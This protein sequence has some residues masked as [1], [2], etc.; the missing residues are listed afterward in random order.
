MTLIG[1]IVSLVLS[2]LLGYFFTPLVRGIAV[3][4]K[5]CEK[6]N[7]C[8]PRDIAHIGGVAI[9]GAIL[10]TLIP[11]FLFH[12][13]HDPLHRAFLPIFIASGF[14]TF[15]LGIIDDLRS[16]HYLYKLF[17]QIVVA[18]SVSA[19][20]M[21]LLQHFGIVQFS[22]PVALVTF[23]LAASWILVIT[24]SF[25]LIDGIDGL[26]SGLALIAAT[27]F[28]VTGLLF[29]MPIVIAL[30]CVVFGSV[31]AFLRYNFPP[32]KIFMG[33]SGSLFLGLMF[34]LI[35]LLLVIPGRQ[36]FYRVAGSIIVLA[37]PFLDTSLAFSR[38]L[39]TGR[40]IFDADL[41]HIHHILLY[42]M[43]SVRWVC[44][45]LWSISAGFGVLGVLTM[46]GN[47]VALFFASAAAVV[48]FGLALRRMVRFEMPQDT[49]R[50]ILGRNGISASRMVHRRD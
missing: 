15:L 21:S 18:I 37:I 28:A 46:L 9:I 3:R 50:E 23:F 12:L 24:T 17:F 13:P 5:I 30:S 36:L 26:A 6:P 7:G 27:S 1:F 29:G 4:W 19:G 40:R 16:L 43:K 38:R 48:V 31:L 8:A 45:V 14:L 25:N 2:F 35:S 39:L 34:G 42:R 32:A 44:F 33:D 49:V 10:F 11:M 41:M 22:L 20:G 47:L